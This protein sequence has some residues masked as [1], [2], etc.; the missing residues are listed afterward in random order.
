MI[1]SINILDVIKFESLRDSN[2]Y[3]ESII[4]EGVNGYYIGVDNTFELERLLKKNRI[5]YKIKNTLIV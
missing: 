1:L 5:R 3:I 4:S 2:D